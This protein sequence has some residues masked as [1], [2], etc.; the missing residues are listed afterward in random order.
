M[1]DLHFD[2]ADPA[3]I[4]D[5]YPTFH[6]LR[7]KGPVHKSVLGFWV[8]TR[9]DDVQ[10]V[11]RDPRLGKET[12][13]KLVEKRTGQPAVDLSMLTRDPPD[14]TRLRGLVA[15]AFTPRV[16]EA[17]RPRVVAMVNELID[18][19][20]EKGETDLMEDFAYPLPITVICELLGVPVEYQET[21]KHWSMDV[22]RGLDAIFHVPEVAARSA[23]A[24][25]ALADFFRALIAERRKAPRNDLLSVL[26]AAEEAGDTLTES[27]LLATCTLLLVAGHETTVNLIGNGTLALLRNPDE[28]KRL[29]E[30]P[31]LA[32]SATE[33]LLR[34]DSPV[35]RTARIG[36]TDIT[37]GDQTIPA[38]EVVMLFFGAA[39]R[40]P[41]RF[42][43]PDRLDIGRT[44]NRHV[45]FSNGIHFCLGAPLA[46][47]E[48][49]IAFEALTR[50]LPNLALKTATPSFRPSVTLRGLTTLPLTY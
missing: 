15:K 33:E 20:L 21:F 7:A 3:F 17:L 26:I 50:R 42:P 16:V 35:Q 39:N 13:Q 27:E 48:G 19:M 9:Y 38:G 28:F 41:A 45:A 6:R 22:A 31:A 43:E 8:V 14:H 46:R 30:N 5:P 32:A 11:L 25:H 47:L 44:D 40:D 24:R 1:D 18:R 49:Q 2:P 12:I 23:A 10:T 4:A 29:R 37:L 36:T 34:Y